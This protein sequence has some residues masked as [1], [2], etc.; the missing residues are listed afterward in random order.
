[1]LHSDGIS[2]RW[3]WEDFSGLTEQPAA[4]IAHRLLQALAKAEDDATVLVVTGA[5]AAHG[6]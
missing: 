3:R 1:V 2:T 6:G 4:T 5:G